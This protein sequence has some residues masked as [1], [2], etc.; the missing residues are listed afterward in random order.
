MTELLEDLDLD[1]SSALLLRAFFSVSLSY[2]L[3]LAVI[4]LEKASA[5]IQ[6]LHEQINR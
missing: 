6:V 3:L 5:L 2:R 1:S 4:T